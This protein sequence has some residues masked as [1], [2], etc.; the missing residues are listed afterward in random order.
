MLSVVPHRGPAVARADPE[1]PRAAH[2]LN[3]NAA[4]DARLVCELL[5]ERA[6]YRVPLLE[7]F[8][9]AAQRVGNTQVVERTLPDGQQP[10]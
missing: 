9:V 5:E 8:D 1:D 6:E 4:I 2:L 3:R 10:D 7:S